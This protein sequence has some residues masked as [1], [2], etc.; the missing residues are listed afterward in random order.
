[1]RILQVEGMRE[2]K[3]KDFKKSVKCWVCDSTQL[4]SGWVGSRDEERLAGG[5]DDSG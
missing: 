5:T 4:L 2:W 1:M 3:K